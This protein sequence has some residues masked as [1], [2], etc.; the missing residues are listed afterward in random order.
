MRVLLN[1]NPQRSIWELRI[2][3]R[4]SNGQCWKAV[5][6][7]IR[8]EDCN[9]SDDMRKLVMKEKGFLDDLK[10]IK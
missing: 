4:H 1:R 6:T 5:P 7:E 3:G 9:E 10:E 8:F 2:V